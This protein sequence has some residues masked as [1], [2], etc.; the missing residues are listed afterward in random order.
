MTPF[1]EANKLLPDNCKKLISVFEDIV[2]LQ[3]PPVLVPP[4]T[5]L[6]KSNMVD[7]LHF[8]TDIAKAELPLVEL[9]QEEYEY[10]LSASA[11]FSFSSGCLTPPES[12]S[13]RR[14]SEALFDSINPESNFSDEIN[15]PTPLRS[16]VR[17]AG[18]T[19]FGHS[20]IEPT[21]S[22]TPYACGVLSMSTRGKMDYGELV[23]EFS[24]TTELPRKNYHDWQSL[25]VH[26]DHP[27]DPIIMGTSDNFFPSQEH[28]YEPFICSQGDLSNMGLVDPNPSSSSPQTILPSQ[29]LVY[30]ST[31]FL[32][33]TTPFEPMN[34]TE[35]FIS[36]DYPVL[37]DSNKIDSYYKSD[38]KVLAVVIKPPRYPKMSHSTFP[39][40]NQPTRR[41][42]SRLKP[43]GSRKHPSSDQDFDQ[44]GS[45]SNYEIKELEV[46]CTTV[47]S[48]KSKKYLCEIC[49]QGFDRQEHW[50]RHEK[51]ATHR[52]KLKKMDK[53]R[54]GPDPP[55]FYCRVCQKGLNRHDNVK[56]H[57][58]S[59]LPSN[60]KT[61]RHTPIPVERSLELG[62]GDMDPRI[63][64]DLKKKT[65]KKARLH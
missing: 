50:K 36:Y 12:N 40:R 4:F 22:N 52:E 29:T 6:L 18:P 17:Q 11:A 51:T 45:N 16:S 60:G 46:E 63:N 61:R 65:R 25:G 1:K 43:V 2:G 28:N 53:A 42:S 47:E 26:G 23:D 24:D 64:P 21:I 41:G 27:G 35:N 54:L 14:P 62:M 48:H 37:S 9:G 20:S 19:T 33:L 8:A 15:S 13:S 34:T 55:M 7:E 5:Y 39:E 44:W 56:P 57:E 58:E 3:Y 30:P 59:H 31:S 38:K 32:G 49:P 10:D